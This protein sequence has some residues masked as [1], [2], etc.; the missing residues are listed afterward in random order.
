MRITH[1]VNQ[2]FEEG[3]DSDAEDK[4]EAAEVDEV[5]KEK[6]EVADDPD[7]KPDLFKLLSPMKR[8]S[9][10]LYPPSSQ[11]EED[12]VETASTVTRNTDAEVVVASLAERSNQRPHLRL[13]AKKLLQNSGQPVTEENIENILKIKLEKTAGVKVE[14][15]AP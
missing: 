15:R 9:G 13:F 2:L 12:D 10:A 1:E 3:T 8:S 11:D 7:Q 14:D 4:D 5:K 6:E